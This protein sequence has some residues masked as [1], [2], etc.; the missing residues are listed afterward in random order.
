MLGPEIAAHAMTFGLK[1][2]RKPWT[3][4]IRVCRGVW[5][6]TLGHLGSWV[7]GIGDGFIGEERKQG[8]HIIVSLAFFCII[9]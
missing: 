1:M 8:K 9:Q 2:T 3:S 7:G 4:S 6:G 5:M